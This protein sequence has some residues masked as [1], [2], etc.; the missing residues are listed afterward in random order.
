[1]LLGKEAV[2]TLIEVLLKLTKDKQRNFIK[3]SMKLEPEIIYALVEQ[4]KEKGEEEFKDM[5]LETHKRA[6]KRYC[7]ENNFNFNKLSS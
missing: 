2:P 4:I 6:L 7:E 3:R 1:N 5:I